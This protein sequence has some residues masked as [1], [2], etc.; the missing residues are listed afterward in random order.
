MLFSSSEIL[1]HL[2]TKQ[3]LLCLL[4]SSEFLCQFY[5]VEKG[6]F[7]FSFHS[8]DSWNSSLLMTITKSRSFSTS[9]AMSPTN[10]L[11]AKRQSR[12]GEWSP[13]VLL[14]SLNFFLGTQ[15]LEHAAAFILCPI[16]IFSINMNIFI[17]FKKIN[18]LRY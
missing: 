10:H 18:G 2:S 4:I 12:Q 5:C 17:Y 16:C 6:L 13:V 15:C 3:F 1:C 7:A 14:D 8:T 9:Y 11:N